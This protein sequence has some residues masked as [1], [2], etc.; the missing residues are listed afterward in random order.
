MINQLIWPLYQ[1]YHHN[2]DNSILIRSAKT[3]SIYGRVMI[4]IISENF[5]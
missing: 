3:D 1:V 5:T 4:N 2:L